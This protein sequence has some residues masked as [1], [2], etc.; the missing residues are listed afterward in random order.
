[1]IWCK[2]KILPIV[3][4]TLLVISPFFIHTASAEETDKKYQYDENGNEISL[5]G[6]NEYKG[7][8]ANSR[9]ETQ[10]IESQLIADGYILV[11]TDYMNITEDEYNT[12]Y[13]SNSAFWFRRF[14]KNDSFG[15]NAYKVYVYAPSFFDYME[16]L[17]EKNVQYYTYR[18]ILASTV[19][20]DYLNWDIVD[21]IGTVS[22]E[23][24]DN[25]APQYDTGYLEIRS[26]VDC[27]V[28]LLQAYTRRYYEFYVQKNNPLLVKVIQGCYHVI[29]VN[30]QS[31]PDNIDNSGEDTLPY[32]NQ[33]QILSEHT[34]DNPYLIDLYDL[35]VKYN[36][37]DADI[38]G[39]PNYSLTGD[40]QPFV[41]TMGEE[42]TVIKPRP[43]DTS[44][45]KIDFGRIVLWSVLALVVL[46]GIIWVVREIIKLKKD[47][48]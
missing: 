2:T 26:P 15:W 38:N 17:E 48:Y 32:N 29:E 10:A 14:M 22:D 20:I 3:L 44:G 18:E 27:R 25:I 39:K 36:I 12:F 7:V 19:V 33:V 45:K 31:V 42:S 34:Q 13:N 16:Q 35:A 41:D 9:E 1:M 40:K 11:T 23:F 47:V 30:K 24:N 46:I 6:I 28:L 37:P 5:G 21:K 4:V 8:M 43:Q